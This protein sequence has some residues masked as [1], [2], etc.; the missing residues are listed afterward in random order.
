MPNEHEIEQYPFLYPNVHTERVIDFCEWI[1]TDGRQPTTGNC[2]VWGLALHSIFQ[3][4]SYYVATEPAQKQKRPAHIAIVRDGRIIDGTGER[5]EH[6]M[7]QYAVA[8]VRREHV[9]M[10]D[11]GPASLSL[12]DSVDDTQTHE[13][14]EYVREQATEYF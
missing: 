2:T 11:W 5:T 1:P 8:G 4:D 12:F 6:D 3:A 13:I 10:C 14:L 9:G 7:K